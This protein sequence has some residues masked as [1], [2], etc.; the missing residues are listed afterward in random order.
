MLF[1]YCSATYPNFLE[2]L[3]LSVQKKKKKIADY[4]IK[5]EPISEL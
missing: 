5:V 1:V 2:H 4:E 3:R